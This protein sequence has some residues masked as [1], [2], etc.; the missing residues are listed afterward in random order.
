MK[1]YIAVVAVLALVLVVAPWGIGRLAQ[2]R[3][4]AGLEEIVKQAPYLNIVERKWSSG[5]FRSQQEVTFEVLG[6]WSEIFREAA[7]AQ[8]TSSDTPLRFTVRNEILHGPVL[9]PAGL[10]I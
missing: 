3:I 2:Q 9:W 6:P 8:K 1:K 10:G 4:D 7:H 5:W